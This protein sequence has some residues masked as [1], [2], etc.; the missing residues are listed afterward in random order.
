MAPRSI[1]SSIKTVLDLRNIATISTGGND[2]CAALV[3]GTAYCWGEAP[4]PGTRPLPLKGV[5]SIQ[6]ETVTS[7]RFLP[8]ARSTAGGTT[9]PVRL[10][11][12]HTPTPCTRCRRPLRCRAEPCRRPLRRHRGR[13]RR[14][15]GRHAAC[16]AP[17]TMASSATARYEWPTVRQLDARGGFRFD[18]R[19]RDHDGW[20]LCLRAA[21]RRQRELL[22]RQRKRHPG[23]GTTTDSASPVTVP[24][25]GNIVAISAASSTP[26]R[27]RRTERSGAGGSTPRASLAMRQPR[28]VHRCRVL[29]D[30]G[31]SRLV[32]GLGRRTGH[33][34]SRRLTTRPG[35]LAVQCRWGRPVGSVRI[36]RAWRDVLPE[37]LVRSIGHRGLRGD[38]WH[39]QHWLL[40]GRGQLRGGCD[41][42][43]TS[44]R[45]WLTPN[46]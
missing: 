24:G 34:I 20:L 25:L 13:V 44:I 33:H 38:S 27:L 28:F 23:N 2:T 22:G 32:D 35:K 18:E 45:A 37:G 43:T 41:G 36:A 12:A 5:V 3:D 6:A 15:G 17:T 4:G 31:E 8:I 7:A 46:R 21:L 30:S 19:G 29:D 16:W 42:N 9:F 39:A 14:P 11:M 40:P 10:A 1:S 26:A